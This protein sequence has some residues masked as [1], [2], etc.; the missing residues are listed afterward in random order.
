MIS[1][2]TKNNISVIIA[3]RGSDRHL[4]DV[5]LD[6]KLWFSDITLVGPSC[7][8]VLEEIKIQGGDWIESESPNICELWE[9]GVRSK[10]SPWCLLLEGREYLYTIGLFFCD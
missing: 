8:A 9:K 4:L 3:Y 5:F 6:L 7:A 1:P 10:N 2:S